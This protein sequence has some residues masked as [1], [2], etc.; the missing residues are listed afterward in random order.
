MRDAAAVACLAAALGP[1]VAGKVVVDAT[2]PLTGFPGLE[3]L[4]DGTSGVQ[5]VPDAQTE[6]GWVHGLLMGRMPAAPV[7][8]HAG[9]ELLQAGLPQGTRVFKA[10]NTL[11]TSVMAAPDALGQRISMLFAG[12]PDDAAGRE[13][14]GALITDAGFAPEFVGPLRYAR[15]LEVR[16]LDALLVEMQRCGHRGVTQPARACARV[17]VVA[18]DGGAVDP[19]C[20]AAGGRHENWGPRFAFQVLRQQEQHD[21]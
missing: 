13:A 5:A 8:Q 15:N 10:F 14:V 7:L 20:G 2:N 17:R 16:W 21:H 18:G 19:P 6:P 9:G 12:P 1:G 3:V 11:G 4:W